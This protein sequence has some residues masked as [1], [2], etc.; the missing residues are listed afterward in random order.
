MLKEQ[1]SNQEIEFL[2]SEVLSS[3]RSFGVFRDKGKHNIDLIFL[4]FIF[5]PPDS[6]FFFF[7]WDVRYPLS[8]LLATVSV[9]ILLIYPLEKALMK[10]S[11]CF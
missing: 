10:H 5:L 1:I 4:Y 8:L 2:S 7:P 11:H 9:S 3:S 6:I